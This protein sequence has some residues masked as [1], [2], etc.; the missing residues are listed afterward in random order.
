MHRRITMAYTYL[1]GWKQHNKFY[2]GVRYSKDCNKSELWKSYFTS[3]NHVKKF[4]EENGDPDIIQVRKTF[5]DPDM[6]RKFETKLLR[7]IKAK[8]RSDF[9]NQTDNIS[10]SLEAAERGRMNRD[11]EEFSIKMKEWYASLSEEELK[12]LNEK[13][14][15]GM[16]NKS[17]ESALSQSKGISS[18][19][20]NSWKDEEQRKKRCESM[21]KPKKRVECPHCGKEGGA[22]TM[23]RW[24]FDNCKDVK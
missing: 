4:S 12:S 9:L 13:K 2:Y 19:Q 1:I 24:H 18:Y 23:K 3:S 7:R 5:D 10:I 16:I 11:P 15:Q 14:R 21:R 6:A 22:N 20:L 17:E 8:D